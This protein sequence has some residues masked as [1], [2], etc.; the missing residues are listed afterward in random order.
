MI[1]VCAC[2]ESYVIRFFIA[3]STVVWALQ[4]MGNDK[5]K[6]WYRPKKALSIELY[7]KSN[8]SWLNLISRTSIA[9]PTIC[10]RI[11]SDIDLNVKFPKYRCFWSQCIYYITINICS[12]QHGDEKILSLS[13]IQQM[14]AIQQWEL[15]IH[16]YIHF[17]IAADNRLHNC[18]S[19]ALS[20]N[21]GGVTNTLAKSLRRRTIELQLLWWFYIIM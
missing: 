5:W 7:L 13:N 17:K 9:Q 8:Q 18:I 16:T 6:H 21:D 10:S 20:I 11:D 15:F 1:Q 19:G 12:Y 14:S 3:P 4:N 2:A